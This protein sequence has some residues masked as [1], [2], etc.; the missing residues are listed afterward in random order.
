MLSEPDT[1]VHSV[2]RYNYDSATSDDT[3]VDDF[4]DDD[5][6]ELSSDSDSS[7]LTARV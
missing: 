5:D 1:C 3:S 2:H 7:Q 4:I 6:I